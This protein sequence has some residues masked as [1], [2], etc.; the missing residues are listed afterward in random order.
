MA[1]EALRRH[2]P[3]AEVIHLGLAHDAYYRLLTELWEAGEGFLIVEHDVEI[4]A[5]VIPGMERCENDWCLHGYFGAGLPPQLLTGSLGCTRFSAGLLARH[6]A[7]MAGLPVRDWR[8]LDCEI[9]P[10]LVA[11]GEKPCVHEPPVDHHHVYA[12]VCACGR[13]HE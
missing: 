13:C 3:G 6:P 12:G 11:L 5:G 4:H 1:V 2:A 8:R 10:R 9:H 7:F